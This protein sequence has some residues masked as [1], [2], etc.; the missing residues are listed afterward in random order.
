MGRFYGTS[1]NA[2]QTICEDALDHWREWDA[3]ITNWQNPI[4]KDPKLPDWYK[5]ALFNELYFIVA[6]GSIWIDKEE[7][8]ETKLAHQITTKSTGNIRHHSLQQD[9]ESAKKILDDFITLTENIENGIMIHH[10]KDNLVTGRIIFSPD[11]IESNVLYITNNGN[12]LLKNERGEVCLADRITLYSR[13]DLHVPPPS[14]IQSLPEKS[15]PS[16]EVEQK[17]NE[18]KEDHPEDLPDTSM[19]DYGEYGLYLYLEGQEYLMYNT[20]SVHFYASFALL[21]LWPQLELNLQRCIARLTLIHEPKNQ[22]LMLHSNEVRPKKLRGAV[23]HDI[24]SPTGDPLYSVNSYCLHDVNSWKDLNS[25]FTLQV[26]R[27]FIATGDRQFLE[28]CY[29][30]V[31][32]A[33]HYLERFDVDRDGMIENTGFPDQTYDTWTATGPSAYCGGL[34]VAALSAMVEMAKILEKEDDLEYYSELLQKA[35]KVYDKLFNGE[36]FRYDT[37]E[38]YDNIIMADQL[39]GQ[40][41]ARASGLPPIAEN[42]HIKQAL[43]TVYNYNV[44]KFHGGQQGAVNGFNKS[45]NIPDYSYMQSS[46]VWTG[47]TFALAANLLQEGLEEE[48]W[49]TAKSLYDCIYD[50]FSYWFQTPE[51]WDER[52]RYRAFGYMG[53]LAIWS[54]QWT[55]SNC[56]QKN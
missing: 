5:A 25:K 15:D 14:P 9:K 18:Q 32:E 55:Y 41:Y 20:Y 34:W 45:L 36:W 11:D 49:A 16:E 28:E 1:G 3:S 7:S 17:K 47:T 48:A 56:K 13:K 37:S 39:V 27:D 30:V 46:E 40:W 22:Q 26:Y 21:S 2:V 4:L 23:P 33:M 54:I 19:F 53:P 6:G 42:E 43:K 50:K 44:V 10:S 51:A 52:G 24:G 35:Y 31:W 12:T 38:K 29:P 8:K